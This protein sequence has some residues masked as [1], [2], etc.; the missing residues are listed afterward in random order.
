MAIFYRT[1]R[2]AASGVSSGALLSSQLDM[3]TTGAGPGHKT[4]APWLHWEVRGG[5]Q[6]GSYAG[7][8]LT[9]ATGLISG[10]W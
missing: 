2:G 1:S 9:P 8:S 7:L 10:P 3:E 4:L 5:L 6:A